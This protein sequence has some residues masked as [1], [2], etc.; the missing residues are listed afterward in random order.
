MLKIQLE[1]KKTFNAKRKS[2]H[3]YKQADLVAI[4]KTQFE[5]GAK[6][7]SKNLG[8]YV[9]THKSGNDRYTVEKIG[10]HSGPNKMTTAADN[11]K[12]WRRIGGQSPNNICMALNSCTQRSRHGRVFECCI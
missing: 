5:T 7:K 11:M 9:V 8:P 1:N 3:Q 6:L 12:I 10:N 4:A 2:A